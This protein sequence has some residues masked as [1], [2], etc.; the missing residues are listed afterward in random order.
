MQGK[1]WEK[2]NWPERTVGDKN[3][4]HEALVEREKILFT[5]LYIKL[6]LMKQYVKILNKDGDCLKYLSNI[7]P[8]LSA[9]KMKAG[10]FDG[11]QI[12]KLIKDSNLISSMNSIEKE[13]WELFVAVVKYC[14]GNR[15]AT[16]YQ[17]IVNKMLRSF[18]NLG[19]NMS[20]KVHLLHS[21]LEKFSPNLGA[22]SDG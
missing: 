14:L 15:K 21:H 5:P 4:I 7:F 2:R 17:E 16:D 8:G 1:A 6:G 19:C 20:T 18:R 22:D 11:P 9:E 12:R 13:A 10:I 3:T